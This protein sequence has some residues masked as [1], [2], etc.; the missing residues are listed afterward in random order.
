MYN[1]KGEGRQKRSIRKTW[2]N[3]REAKESKKKQTARRDKVQTR[4]SILQGVFLGEQRCDPRQN[5]NPFGSSIGCLGG[6]ART[7]LDLITNLQTK[8]RKQ[9][10][11][12]QI[13][14]KKS[15]PMS[16]MKRNGAKNKTSM[17]GKTGK[18]KERWWWWWGGGGEGE[19][20]RPK[21]SQEGKS[22][23]DTDFENS[24]DDGSSSNT[25]FQLLH[26]RARLVHIER[27]NDDE[28]RR[29]KKISHRNRDLLT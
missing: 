12:T 13:E 15:M 27:T 16:D 18:Q 21:E 29:G 1:T 14:E 17:E 22:V 11:P 6:N 28:F 4:Y 9:G 26:R 25:A 2:E 19:K 5:W 8:Q 10:K 23:Q 20:M 3:K 7:D 24:F